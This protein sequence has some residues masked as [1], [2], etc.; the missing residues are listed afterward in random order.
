MPMGIQIEIPVRWGDMDALRHVNNT[1]YFQYCESARIA[2]FEK[3][4]A[5]PGSGST[6]GP[7][8]VAAELSFR[9][10]VHYPATLLVFA[11]AIKIGR[12]SFTLDYDIREESMSARMEESAAHGSSVVVWVDYSTGKPVPLP[13]ELIDRI[14]ELEK[15]PSLVDGKKN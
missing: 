12:T 10:P 14:V 11:T 13:P 3:I 7:S 4:G 5:V 6:L 8:L 2:Y 9:R 15:N 1:T